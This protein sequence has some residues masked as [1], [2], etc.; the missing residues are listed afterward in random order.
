M[1][2]CRVFT[3]YYIF[4]LRGYIEI[5]I[6]RIYICGVR[7]STTCLL[8]ITNGG[9]NEKCWVERK[10]RREINRPVVGFPLKR[11]VETRM[12]RSAERERAEFYLCMV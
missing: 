4:F 12:G 8:I 1:L 5:K 7:I 11:E 9:E 3:Y 2:L 10:K 6:R